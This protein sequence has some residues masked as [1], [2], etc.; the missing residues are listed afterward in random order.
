MMSEKEYMMGT[1]G[2]RYMLVCTALALAVLSV[3]AVASTGDRQN[4]Q[5][6]DNHA[7]ATVPG[8]TQQQPTEGMQT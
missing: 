1:R 6:Y 7:A 8:Q 4:E 2:N 3:G 5:P